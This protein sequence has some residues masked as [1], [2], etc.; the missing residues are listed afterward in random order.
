ML[1]A[2]TFSNI[3]RYFMKGGI[4][5]IIVIGTVAVFVIVYTMFVNITDPNSPTGIM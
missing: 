2:A 5:M 4:S 1:F 3:Y